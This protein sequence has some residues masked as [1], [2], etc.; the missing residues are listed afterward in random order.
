[1]VPELDEVLEA[2]RVFLGEVVRLARVGGEVV[3]LP[4]LGAF[5][6]RDEDDLPVALAAGGAALSMW[7]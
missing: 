7:K 3:E 1:L 6:L 5:G 2:V 4:A